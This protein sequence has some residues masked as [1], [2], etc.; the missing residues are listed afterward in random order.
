[1]TRK[2]KMGLLAMVLA[3][4]GLFTFGMTAFGSTP[5]GVK[6]L[7]HG[8]LPYYTF[9]KGYNVVVATSGIN[10]S[11]RGSFNIDAS[12]YDG[13]G[14][15]DGDGTLNIGNDDG[16]VWTPY[17]NT[18]TNQVEGNAFSNYLNQIGEFVYGPGK[19]WVPPG[20]PNVPPPTTTQGLTLIWKGKNIFT[21]NVETYVYQGTGQHPE[22]AEA[23]K[24]LLTTGS[25][26]PH[27]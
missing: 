25:P 16:V 27:P 3:G 22:M 13:D 9:N 6:P 23:A 19:A 12:A 11:L 2:L 18:A 10:A 17:I 5:A 21:N 8:T 4:V 26:Y 14:N 7:P 1:M 24:L 20:Y 15:N